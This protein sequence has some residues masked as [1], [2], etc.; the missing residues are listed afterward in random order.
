MSDQNNHN[1]DFKK[2]LAENKE[3][4]KELACINET[5]KII[6]E[7]KSVQE[8]LQMIVLRLPRAWQYPEYTV[9]RIIYGGNEFRSPGFKE[10]QWSQKQTFQTID[11]EEGIIEVYYTIDFPQLFEGPFLKEERDLIQI[12]EENL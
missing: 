12:I 5:T 1:K 11:G 2:L 6:K 7:G 4:L 3:R 8:T 9:A 10:T